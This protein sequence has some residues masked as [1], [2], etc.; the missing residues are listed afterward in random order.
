MYKYEIRTQLYS[1]KMS[2]RS[3]KLIVEAQ[4]QNEGA[5]A[6]VRRSIGSIVPDFNPFLLC[7]HFNSLG[8]RGFP[9]HPHKGQE[10][11]TLLL[12]G[13]YAHEDFTG[14]KGV[15]YAGD[16]QF[17]TSG[18]GVVHS[19]MPV[20][21]IN[22][23]SNAG[24]QLWIDLPEDLKE[25]EPRYRDLREWEIPQVIQQDGKL[26]IKVISGKSYGIESIKDL[27]YT[28][29]EYYYFT[30]QPGAHFQQEVQFGFN[31][32]LYIL[33]GEQLKINS[34]QVAHQYNNVFFNMDG[35][36]IEGENIGNDEVQ[37]VLVG[38]KV[39]DQNMIHIGAFSGTNMEYIEQAFHDFTSC[40]NGFARRKNWQT[41]ISNGVTKEMI[42]G[43]LGGS[44]Q[45]RMADKAR[46]LGI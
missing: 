21:S 9:E 40:T 8:S 5:G 22:G 39:L 27:A 25:V 35:D 7:D 42:E 38:G 32:F 23:T 33:Q 4:Q 29:M 6:R 20:P 41:L 45:K 15:L 13:G 34:N 43:P 26:R 11:I 17:M 1:P 37:F 19:E 3:I 46:Y 18:R 44:L 24:I 14:S 28:P 30:M 2:L 36:S 10:T 16:L 31:Y 12:S